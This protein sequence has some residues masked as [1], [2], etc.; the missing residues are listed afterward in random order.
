MIRDFTIET[1]NRLE[2]QI[3]KVSTNGFFDKITDGVMDLVGRILKVVGVIGLEDDMS[4]VKEYQKKVLDIYNITHNQLKEIFEHVSNCDT[5]YAVGDGRFQ[6][7][8]LTQSVYNQKLSQLI[9]CIGPNFEILS[10]TEI[11]TALKDINDNLV[12]YRTSIYNG[13]LD[14]LDW[15]KKE[16]TKDKLKSAV[17]NLASAIGNIGKV[18]VYFK[19]GHPIK[20]V[21]SAWNA[22]DDL[23][24]IC[25][26]DVPS[27][28]NLALYSTGSDDDKEKYLEEAERHADKEGISG[29]L[30][31]MGV[32]SESAIVKALNSVDTIAETA[33]LVNS[34][35]DLFKSP[36]DLKNGTGKAAKSA[37][38]FLFDTNFGLSDIS[39]KTL[40]NVDK[41]NII[42]KA[43]STGE[44]ATRYVWDAFDNDIDGATDTM[45]DFISGN[46]PLIKITNKVIDNVENWADDVLD[47][48]GES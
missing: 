46:A 2:T 21:I 8:H 28:W 1:Y 23:F 17:G 47:W 11:N 34:V 44:K 27:L 32:D 20:G 18:Y 9:L 36:Q 48:I 3:D 4:N 45:L 42:S 29:G 13:Y 38:D 5:D 40:N 26:S 16:L 19:T 41:V 39:E 22:V 30:E 15:A 43:I 10:S 7:I 14:A 25:I 6:Q 37:K 31:L 33:G 35:T 12:T 24:T